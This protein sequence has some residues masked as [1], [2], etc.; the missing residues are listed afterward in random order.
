MTEKPSDIIK[1]LLDR[2]IAF[3]RAFV[4]LGAGITG[5]LL[6]SQAVYWSSRTADP[7]GWFY[8]SAHE[9]ED[10]TGLTR[11]E[12]ELARKKLR[13]LG[14]IQYELRGT[15][16]VNFYVVDFDAL[17]DRLSVCT[18][19]ANLIVRN[20][21]TSLHETAKQVCTKRAIFNKESETTTETTTEINDDEGAFAPLTVTDPE[22]Y[23]YS[24]ITGYS[25]FP[26]AYVKA[27]ENARA[28]IRA[29]IR[30]RNN[31][32]QAAVEYLQ[33]FWDEYRKRRLPLTAFYWLDWALTGTIP[34]A[35]QPAKG[36][37]APA[38]IDPKEYM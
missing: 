7:D 5:A 35:R 34:D 19:R 3:Q 4:S 37:Q 11:R 14:V 28:T 24:K 16:A 10:E 21:Q 36:K 26:G 29:I 23:V 13:E 31:D 2:P 12:F 6:L 38:E 8:K 9:W 20:V 22:F 32:H 15:P 27:T 17:H 1:H 25:A 30:E 33:P 18:K